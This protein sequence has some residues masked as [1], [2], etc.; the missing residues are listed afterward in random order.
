MVKPKLERYKNYYDGIQDILNKKYSDESKPCNK[1]VINY[2]KNIT[3]S[4]NG[5]MATPG[6]ISYNSEQDIEDIMDILCSPE[7]SGPL[8]N[9]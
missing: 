9:D 7:S 3:D 2:C 5:Y 4:Y 6:H 8:P 1:T